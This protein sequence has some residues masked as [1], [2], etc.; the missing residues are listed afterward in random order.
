MDKFSSTV[1]AYYEK[2]F[3]F[4]VRLFMKMYPIDAKKKNHTNSV[5]KIKYQNIAINYTIMVY[6]LHVNFMKLIYISLC[7]KF[8]FL[9][10]ATKA[11]KLD[12]Y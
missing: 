3:L 4:V 12:L 7:N 5:L 1:S 9:K 8:H 10:K 2:K 6:I 11:I